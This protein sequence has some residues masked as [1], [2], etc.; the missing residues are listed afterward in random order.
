MKYDD[1]FEATAKKSYKCSCGY[2]FSRKSD[3]SKIVCP[4]CGKSS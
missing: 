2:G 4:W 1:D 3:Y